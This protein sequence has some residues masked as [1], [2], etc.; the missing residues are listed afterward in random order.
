LLDRLLPERADNAYHGH[1]LAPWIFGALVLLKTV[2][3]VNSI[4]LGHR[5]ATSADGIPLDSFPA[6]AAGTVISMFAVLGLSRLVMS[7]LSVLVLLRYRSLIPL[8]FVLQLLE[9]LGSR[10]IH[11]FLPFATTGRPVGSLVTQVLLA[12]MVVGLILSLWRRD[13]APAAD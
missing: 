10:L 1:R 3:G 12:L 7:L 8:M 13:R 6:A 11:H 2:I 9:H 4:F 5:V